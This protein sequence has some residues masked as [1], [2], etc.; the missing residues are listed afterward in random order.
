MN[1]FCTPFTLHLGFSNF[2]R[3]VER[4]LTDFTNVARIKKLFIWFRISS[5]CSSCSKTVSFGIRQSVYLTLG[6]PR[7][8]NLYYTL[9]FFIIIHL[10]W[11]GVPRV[12]GGDP[13]ERV[14]EN[15]DGIFSASKHS[16]DLL[17]LKQSTPAHPSSKEW[18]NVIETYQEGVEIHLFLLTCLYFICS[19]ELAQVARHS[20]QFVLVILCTERFPVYQLHSIRT[21]QENLYITRRVKTSF[22]HKF[23]LLH[24]SNF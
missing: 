14:H 12:R 18:P 21:D 4:K 24:Q 9:L 19:A 17:S 15:V 2:S 23:Y 10:I 16:N 22:L 6:T 1:R 3:M 13:S 5:L 8:N 20:I 11:S 7:R